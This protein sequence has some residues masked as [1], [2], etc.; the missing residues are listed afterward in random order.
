MKTHLKRSGLTLTAFALITTGL[1][2]LTYELTAPRIKSQEQQQLQK[3]LGSIVPPALHDNDIEHDC[4]EVTNASLLGD[5]SAKTIYR[6]RLQ[7]EPVALVLQTMTPDGYSGDIELLVGVNLAGE[8]TGV[9]VLKHQET[10]GLGDKIDIRISDW[11]LSFN[12]KSIASGEQKY[13]AVKKDGGQFDQFTGA[14]ITPRAMVK[15][16]KNA[17]LLA[18]EQQQMLFDAPNQCLAHTSGDHNE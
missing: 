5:D 12:G 14:T 1:I 3:I 16:V 13:W 6:A 4:T 2:A 17:L 8:V 9:R 7:G 10:P 18:A 11:I 15:A